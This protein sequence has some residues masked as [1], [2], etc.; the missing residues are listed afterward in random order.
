[1]EVTS[2]A[3][4]VSVAVREVKR[5]IIGHL[6]FH[7]RRCIE[8]KVVWWSG[9]LV[10]TVV[11]IGWRVGR[12]IARWV[13]GPGPLILIKRACRERARTKFRRMRV[14]VYLCVG[15]G[16]GRGGERVKRGVGGWV[17]GGAEGVVSAAC[18][19]PHNPN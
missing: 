18:V 12:G 19:P 11:V 6:P 10:V 17:E 14:P 3:Y 4:G 1:M 8:S 5:M 15:E 9:G 2:R 16:G 7:N 13:G